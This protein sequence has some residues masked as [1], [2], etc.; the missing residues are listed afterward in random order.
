MMMM[1]DLF[2]EGGEGGDAPVDIALI[3]KVLAYY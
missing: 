1:N 3:D 2:E